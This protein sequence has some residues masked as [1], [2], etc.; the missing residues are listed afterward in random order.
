[1]NMSINR[2]NYESYFLDYLE[3][4]L[5][6]TDTRRL[7]EFLSENTDLQEELKQFETIE[8][9]PDTISF[10]SKETL[11]RTVIQPAIINSDNFDN[12]CV[13]YLEHDLD[14]NSLQE[15]KNYLATHPER[16]K[17]YELHSKTILQVDKHIIFSNKQGLKKEIPRNKTYSIYK[18]VAAAAASTALIVLAYNYNNS[19]V[20]N[21][22]LAYIK[23]S[24]QNKTTLDINYPK[25]IKKIIAPQLIQK[26][27]VSKVANLEIE[28]I[29]HN[30]YII[31]PIASINIKQLNN[32]NNSDFL[33]STNHQSNDNN[34][35]F[36]TTKQMEN[37]IDIKAIALNE[38]NKRINIEELD[39]MTD[40]RN[41]ISLG[42]KG[43][44][45]INKIIGNVIS[46]EKEEDKSTNRVM[47]SLNM[48]LLSFYSSHEKK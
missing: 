47:Y 6:S 12:Y 29:E 24:Q 19:K 37:I 4:K 40:S 2:H 9:K 10:N 35:I 43:I 44:R 33:E 13:A 28:K 16:N 30:A 17:D 39:N 18:Y 23:V 26:N 7:M 27:N 32:S 20:D 1:M 21:N 11:K 46:I 5:T 42:N 22:Q 14:S 31:E 41:F 34:E 25:A 3:G 38:I 36:A 48:P 15:L 8:L 45:I